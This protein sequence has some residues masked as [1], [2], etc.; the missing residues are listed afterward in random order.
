MAKL[1]GRHTIVLEKKPR[2]IGFA[3]AAGKKE[4]EGPLGKEFDKVF[5]DAT[6]GE[7]TWEKAESRLLKT[8]VTKAISKAGIKP[9]DIGCVFSGDLLNQCT[10]SAFGLCDFGMPFAGLYGA[11]STMALGLC[12]ASLAVE[13]GGFEY[14]AAATSSHFCSAEKQFRLP[15][16]YGGQRTPTAQWT[17]T[18]AGAAILHS[19]K[20]ESRPYIDSVHIGAMRDY[21]VTDANNMGAAMAPAAAATICGFLSDTG[22]SPSDFDM[23]VTGDLGFV[24]SELLLEL[25]EKEHGLDLRS[26]HKDCGL[27]IFDRERQDVHAGGS[28][29]GC[30]ASV[31]CGHILPAIQKGRL[32][33]VLFTATGAMMS[34]VSSLQGMSIP[35]VAHAVHIKGGKTK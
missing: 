5:D 30:S 13:T 23:I 34:P 18:G 19:E 32:K 2:L 3:A 31:L 4:G 29:C 8:A 10:S 28:G 24:G 27:M 16:E 12:I 35:G 11:C 9:E 14:A 1:T 20:S 26:V 33:N 7:D 15:L 25:A 6:L 21:G 17:V 22:L